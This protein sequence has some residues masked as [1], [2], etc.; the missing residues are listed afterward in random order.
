MKSAIVALVGSTLLLMGLSTAPAA[1]TPPAITVTF[2]DVT[3][4]NPDAMDY[5][6][7]VE[8]EV[9][10]REIVAFGPGVGYQQLAAPGDTTL[11]F[12]RDGGEQSVTVL[13]CD[14]GTR[15]DIPYCS[16]FP[17]TCGVLATRDNLSV[18]R[19]LH[20]E[21]GDYD[22]TVG[23]GTPKIMVA[24]PVPAGYYGPAM[25][26]WALVAAKST[27]APALTSGTV[28]GSDRWTY[29]LPPAIADGD[30]W[31]RL[32]AQWSSPDHPE[33]GELEGVGYV[34]ITVD[35]TAPRGVM[36]SPYDVVYPYR[37]N[38]RDETSMVLKS[39]EPVSVMGYEV[40]DRAGR[41]VL[42]DVETP[43]VGDPVYTDDNYYRWLGYNSQRWDGRL[44]SKLVPGT[45]D[46]RWVG[47]DRA[48][49]EAR[50]KP[51][52]IRVSD[53]RLRHMEWERTFSASSTIVD[54]EVGSCSTLRRPA[55]RGWRGSVG[56]LSQT[57]CRRAADS[58]AATINA[59]AV[60][61]V[62]GTGVD[63]GYKSL[64]VSLYGGGVA[65]RRT[66][67][68]VMNTITADG[69]AVA[70]RAQFG[71]ALGRHSLAEANV[72]RVVRD[73][74]TRPHIVWQTGL[75]DGSRYDVKS[76]TVTVGYYGLGP[77]TQ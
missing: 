47:F 2:P 69:R 31:L 50:T 71:P 12:S 26:D 45:Y 55:T 58:V 28:D 17:M 18:Y 38:Y 61:K 23:V 77:P 7:H 39:D 33:L 43:W 36:S 51:V 62:L 75:T 59:V 25:L 1:A 9:G 37:D 3:T 74:K 49:N 60:P 6:V 42:R 44:G 21:R 11:E 64:R 34:P 24:Y 22:R 29:H 13:Y 40:R 57:R 56:Y 46:F 70:T 52:R 32:S 65:G 53:H 66:P 67:Y 63:V 10:T 16:N 8:G 72:T 48:E 15:C 73:A 68:L 35:V 27:T 20:F 41:L 54:T 76:F 4:F 5:V 14:P 19:S 30:Y